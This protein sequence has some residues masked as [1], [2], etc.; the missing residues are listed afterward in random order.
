M[1]EDLMTADEV[2]EHFGIQPA[3]VRSTMRR[4]GITEQRGYPR[5]QVMALERKPRGRPPR[6][7]TVSSVGIHDWTED[8]VPEQARVVEAL[9]RHGVDPGLIRVTPDKTWYVGEGEYIVALGVDYDGETDEIWDATN[10]GDDSLVASGDLETVAS[11]VAQVV[12]EP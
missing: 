1:S 10:Q 12:I 7:G 8:D 4:Y 2:A 5:E 11:A 9:T 3:S 6:E